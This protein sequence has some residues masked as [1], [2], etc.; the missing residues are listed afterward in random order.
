MQFVPSTLNWRDAHELLVGI[1]V[2]RPIALVSTIG[3]NGVNN[4][5][6]FSYYGLLSIKPAILYIGVGAKVRAKQE[7]DTYKNIQFANDFVV[8]VVDEALAEPMNQTSADY[9]SDVDEFK[10]AGLTA[11]A[12]ELVKSPRVA[13]SPISMECKVW[14]ILTFGKFPENNN[15]VL[16][17]IV[18]VHVRDDLWVNDAVQMSK[19][20]AIARLGEELFCRTGDVFELKR[21]YILGQ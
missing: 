10:E 7:K 6:P 17:E 5:A 13:E 9:P 2:P 4:V 12:S 20:K 8:N 19:L 15:V 16:G 1:V 11:V 18:K 3:E 14:Q 21:P